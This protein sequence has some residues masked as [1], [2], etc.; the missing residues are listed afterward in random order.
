MSDIEKFLKLHAK[1][2]ND[3]S[4]D[5][6]RKYLDQ[7]L[8]SMVDWKRYA[9]KKIKLTKASDNK[10]IEQK[11]K[12]DGDGLIRKQK[13][14]MLSIICGVLLFCQ[15][16]K[17]DWQLSLRKKTFSSEK[18]ILMLRLNHSQ[19]LKRN[20]LLL[21]FLP[22]VLIYLSIIPLYAIL[23][24]FLCWLMTKTL[25]RKQIIFRLTYVIT[26]I[27]N[28]YAYK[29]I[30]A[31]EF[32]IILLLLIVPLAIDYDKEKYHSIS[33]SIVSFITASIFI[34]KPSFFTTIFIFIWIN[35]FL[36]IYINY[37]FNYQLNMN[38]VNWSRLIKFLTSIIFI[39][40][41]IFL[42]IPRF[43]VTLLSN[44]NQKNDIGLEDILNLQN[45]SFISTEKNEIYK[46]KI[47][48]SF[49]KTPY[50]KVFVLSNYDNFEWSKNQEFLEYIPKSINF[51]E[52][53]SY[54]IIKNK[55]I[56]QKNLPVLG[57]YP[58][59]SGVHKRKLQLMV[60]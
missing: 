6:Y 49:K 5:H 1:K 14:H 59:K 18:K 39:V 57:N 15:S 22:V 20:R 28:L 60:N 8:P 51:D 52:N 24:F 34:F 11:I 46:I 47:D 9:S 40:T 41:I 26:V 16:K 37:K 7:D 55:N 44:K 54:K 53:Y 29:N 3:D 33:L 50:W 32:W 45:D 23:S 36:A 12:I 4:Y 19:L 27:I 2:N 25:T 17:I 42:I 13:E 56:S 31:A 30:F 43:Q 38:A 58:I 35:F 48:G 10:K 21:I